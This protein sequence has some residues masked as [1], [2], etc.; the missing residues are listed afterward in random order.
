MKAIIGAGLVI[1]LLAS[2]APAECA[3]VLWAQRTEIPDPQ[4]GQIS[5][6][7]V[8]QW[9]VLGPWNDEGACMREIV[10][11]VDMSLKEHGA[12]SFGDNGVSYKKAQGTSTITW[13]CF[14]DNIDPGAKGK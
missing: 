11:I 5:V 9:N 1:A 12:S 2:P 7:G 3:W 14:P 10:R 8:T 4:P 13:L 6:I